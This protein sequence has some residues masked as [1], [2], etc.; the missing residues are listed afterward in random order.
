MTTTVVA[1]AVVERDGCIL[2]TRRIKGTHLE[3]YWEFPGGKCESGETLHA[4][5]NRELQEELAVDAIVGDALLST[6]HAY[7]ERTVVIHFFSVRLLG[8]P[9]PQMGQEMQWIRREDLS[10]LKL[11]PADGEL[12]ALL[13][14]P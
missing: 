2:V 4:C 10:T 11:P 13:Q 14:A 6:T 5:L 7:P 1:A 12:V 9:T 8:E 3:G